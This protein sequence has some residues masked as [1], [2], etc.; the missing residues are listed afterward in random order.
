MH[1]QSHKWASKIKDPFP[2]VWEKIKEKKEKERKK[3]KKRREKGK[4]KKRRKKKETKNIK[5][6][7]KKKE[8]GCTAKKKGTHPQI[9][10]QVFSSGS[11]GLTILPQ[12]PTAIPFISIYIP[13]N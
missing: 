7:R 1:I 12:Q 11:G 10:T 4:R 13:L 3:G 2:I 5:K 6:E 9:R 8:R